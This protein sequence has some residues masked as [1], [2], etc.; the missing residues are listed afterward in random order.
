MVGVLLM[1]SLIMH[2]CVLPFGCEII[3]V[4]YGAEQKVKVPSTHCDVR[5]QTLCADVMSL[6]RDQLRSL[7]PQ[8]CEA[9]QPCCG[10]VANFHSNAWNNCN[11]LDFEM[12]VRCGCG[13]DLDQQTNRFECFLTLVSFSIRTLSHGYFGLEWKLSNNCLLYT[14]PS[15]RD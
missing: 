2:F 15:P 11:H 3:P 6:P 4:L 8:V 12:R 14:S 5:V 9:V 7:S 13:M 1:K 10:F